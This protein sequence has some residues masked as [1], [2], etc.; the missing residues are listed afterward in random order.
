[1]LVP[2]SW[3]LNEKSGEVCIKAKSP[4]ASLALIGQVAKHTTVEGLLLTSLIP[5]SQIFHPQDGSRK[6]ILIFPLVCRRSE[7][8]SSISFEDQGNVR[9]F[10]CSEEKRL[11]SLV[12]LLSVGLLFYHNLY[13]PV[14]KCAFPCSPGY[15]T[16]FSGRH[17]GR[18]QSLQL[19]P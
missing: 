14:V 12:L 3:H 4:P 8:G 17:T 10:N 1:M 5:R 7:K 11:Y 16:N 13:I 15:G 6:K 9:E 2:T 18:D 19:V